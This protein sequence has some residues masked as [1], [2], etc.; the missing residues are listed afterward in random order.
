MMAADYFQKMKTLADTMAS[1]GSPLQDEEI[2][3]YMLTGLGSEYEALVTTKDT[4]VSFTNFY[5][6]HQRRASH[7]AQH[8][9]RRDPAVWA[10]RHTC[11]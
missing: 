9:C 1:I 4:P 6:S 11:S 2:L 10:L 8:I 7:R 5:A 3:G